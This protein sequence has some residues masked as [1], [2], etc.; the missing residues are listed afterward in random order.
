MYSLILFYLIVA[1]V[2][3]LTIIHRKYTTNKPTVGSLFFG[4]FII[5][6]IYLL[7][8]L[9]GGLA[10][11]IVYEKGVYECD[12]MSEDQEK[13]FKMIGFDVKT[14]TGLFYL[15][16]VEQID[17]NSYRYTFIGHQWLEIELLPGIWIP[18]ESTMYCFYPVELMHELTHGDKE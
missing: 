16:H 17:V 7:W 5:S 13:F 1:G 11:S 10:G 8:I 3:S 14:K 2:L 4:V 6:F 9:I 12:D 15:D 18:W